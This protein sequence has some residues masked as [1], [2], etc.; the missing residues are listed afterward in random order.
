MFIKVPLDPLAPLDCLVLLEIPVH[1]VLKVKRDPEV[2]PELM[3][4]MVRLDDKE[5]PVTLEKTD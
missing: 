4:Q 1:Q 5:Q 2:N 3:V